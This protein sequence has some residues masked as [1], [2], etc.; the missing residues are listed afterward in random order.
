MNPRVHPLTVMA[1]ILTLLLLAGGT[2]SAG[3][4]RT[5]FTGSQ[6]WVAVLEAGEEYFPDGKYLLRGEVDAF[7]FTASDPRLDQATNTVTINCNFT[8][9]PE[10]VFVS[11]PMWGTFVLTNAG[12]AWEGSW[13][14]FRDENGFSYFHFVGKG[15]GGYAGLHLKMWGERLDPNPMAPESYHGVIIEVGG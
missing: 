1:V 15:R 6:T 13:N 7:A 4:P 3:A 11:G 9:L 8:L 5:E 2:A 14:G 12:G 10:P